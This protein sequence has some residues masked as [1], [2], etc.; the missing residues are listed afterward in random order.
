MG[1][2]CP[3][4][5][6]LGHRKSGDRIRADDGVSGYFQDNHSRKGGHAALPHQ[7]VDSIAVGAQVV[8]NLQHIASRCTDPL[9]PLVLSVTRFVGGNSHNVLPG[10]V[11][12][13]GTVRT[14]D[15]GLRERVPGQIERVVKG[16]TEA[17]GA[18]Y[19]L[20]YKYGY[21]PSLTIVR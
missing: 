20:E 3:P 14:L 13:E 6:S 2:R 7:T 16:I 11:E 17:H 10:S 8:T 18:R 4:V 21:R 15:T 19:E 5:V 1:D 9:E 12:I